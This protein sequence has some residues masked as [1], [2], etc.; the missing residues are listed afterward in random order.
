LKTGL[1]LLSALFSLLT[2]AGQFNQSEEVMLINGKCRL[3]PYQNSLK[4]DFSLDARRSLFQKNWIAIGGI[5]FGVE[6]RR[7]HRLGIGVYFL[8]TRVF[9]DSFE[10]DVDAEKVE[11]DFNYTSVYYDRV[12]FF[13]RKWETGATLHLGGGNLDVYYQSPDNPNVRQEGPKVDFSVAEI[14]VYGEYS[15]LFWLGLG[16]GTGYRQVFGLESDVRND[17]SS[18][19]FVVNLQLKLIKLARSY[20]DESVRHEF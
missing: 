8:N 9:D 16:V 1:L 2:A 14:G 10:L 4:P 5:K 18:P 7:V 6:Y 12:L 11:Y 19:I 15:P 13:N 17:L 3:L 20:F